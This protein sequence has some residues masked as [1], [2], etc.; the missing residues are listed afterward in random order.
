M[1]IEEAKKYNAMLN[2]ANE[3][4]Q[5]VTDSALIEKANEHIEALKNL[6]T[7]LN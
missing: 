4:P 1:K 2:K 6:K 3:I 5:L 7:I